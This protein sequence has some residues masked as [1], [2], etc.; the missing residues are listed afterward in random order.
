M[1]QNI[2]HRT[3]LSIGRCATAAQNS[4]QHVSTYMYMPISTCTH[5]LT[6]EYFSVPY[7]AKSAQ[8]LCIN[9]QEI[10]HDKI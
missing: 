2:Q 5:R 1:K 3:K 4:S 8:N 7:R 6:N 10:L 9:L